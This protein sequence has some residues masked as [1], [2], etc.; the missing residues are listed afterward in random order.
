MFSSTFVVFKAHHVTRNLFNFPETLIEITVSSTEHNGDRP[1]EI[2]KSK[3]GGDVLLLNG[4][5]YQLQRANT[6]HKVWRCVRRNICNAYLKTN[7]TTVLSE[8]AHSCQQNF[9]ENE[10]KAK[11]DECKRRAENEDTPLSTI[12]AEV[13]QEYETASPE[14]INMIPKF[15]N[16]QKSL[17]RHRNKRNESQKP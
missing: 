6:K 4:Y 14:I 2:V 1:F 16:C 5:R 7:S 8:D 13:F 3:R 12:Y 17:Y 15:A 11:M 10:I 9:I